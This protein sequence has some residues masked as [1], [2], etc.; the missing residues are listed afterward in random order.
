MN[1]IFWQGIIS[2]H[3]KTILEALARHSRVKKVTLVVER[4]ISAYRANMGWEVPKI[5]SVEIILSPDRDRVKQIF[6]SNKDAYHVLGGIRVGPM[7]TMALEEGAKQNARMGSLSEPYDRTGIKGKLRDLKYRYLR[8]FYFKHVDYFL[9]VG[10]EGVKTYT[11]LGFNPNRVFAWAYFVTVPTVTAKPNNRDTAPNIIYAGRIEEGKG[12]YRFVTE[13]A[14]NRNAQ[15]KL[16]IFGGGPDEEKL[17]AFVD[18]SNLSDKIRF[19]PFLKYDD[20]VQQYARY[21]WVV[22]PSTRKDGWGVVI[23]EGLLNGLK[24]ICSSICGV[25]W[26]IIDNFN[27]VT[28]DWSQ[29]GSCQK[30]IKAM[31]SDR[32]FADS[33]TI[34]GW[35]Q[36]SL[37][38]EAGANYYL[39]ILDCVYHSKE[40][41]LPPWVANKP[42]SNIS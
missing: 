21:D 36:A 9:A 39:D 25:S 20:M 26:A 37:S 38:G 11:R 40:M 22:L 42:N 29:A 23:S 16:E 28:F 14:E 8:L 32:G 12:I 2:I 3:Q 41:P 15:F 18:E 33:T 5:E 7:M 4:D 6:S 27:G 10:K 19:Y 35:A 24:G 31:L 1:I 13:L 17:K 34:K 30:A